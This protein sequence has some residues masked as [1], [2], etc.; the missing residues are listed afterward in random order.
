MAHLHDELAANS[1]RVIVDTRYGKV[2]GGRASNGAAVF[3]EIPYALPPVRFVDAE[4]LPDNHRYP[5]GKEYLTESSYCFQPHNDGQASGTPFA[6]KVGYGKPTENLLF[7]NIISPPSFEPKFTTQ[8]FPVK[9]YIHGGFLQ[10]GS[11]HG[12]RGQDQFVSAEFSEVRVNIGYRLSAFGFLAS[13]QP[14][15]DGNYGFKDQWLALEWVKKNINSFGGDPENITLLGLSAGAHSV[16]Q[17]LHHV[18]RLPETV[19]S[20]F[21]SAILMSNAIVM[22]PKPPA[23]LRPQFEAL[24]QALSLD[25]QS[26]DVLKT[27]QDRSLVPASK[28]CELIETDALGTEHGTFRG[29][30]DDNSWMASSPDLMTWQRSGSLAANLTKKGIRSIVIGDLTE[31]WYLY[32]IAHPIH[33][34]ADVAVNLE[35]Y[36]PMDMV[37]RMMGMYRKLEE[38]AGKDECGRLF[39]EILSD[40]QV[41]LPVRL[42]ARDLYSAGFPVLR[43]EIAWTPEQHRPEG[44]YVTHASDSFLWHLREPDLEPDQVK[45]AKNWLKRIDEEVKNMEHKGSS[46]SVKEVL[47]LGKDKQIVWSR[48]DL[49]DNKIRLVKILQGE[50]E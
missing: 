12:L 9:I 17:I 14:R 42:F 24:C 31:E 36:Y 33:T 4:P 18:S 38:N 7:L 32:S 28:I 5:H 39:G 21:Q 46:R 8:I 6:D 50:S 3:L 15:L 25:P 47:K 41:H 49:W 40:W 16:H 10:F 37:E 27:L 43:Y 30:E 44:G 29:C 13:D 48:D 11:P 23:E 19:Q 34:A 45:V 26:P 22:V 20:P 35:R 1:A 2:I